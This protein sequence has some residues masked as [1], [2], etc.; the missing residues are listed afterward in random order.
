LPSFNEADIPP[1][2]LVGFS[3]NGQL[4]NSDYHNA[5]A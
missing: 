5:L 1:G 2:D 4:G 3:A